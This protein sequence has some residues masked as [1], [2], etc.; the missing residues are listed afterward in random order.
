MENP[1]NINIFSNIQ[2][3]SLSKPE[4]ML[5][6]LT[7]NRSRQSQQFDIN[8]IRKININK[9]KASQKLKLTYY[10]HR[11][12]SD[13]NHPKHLL[14]RNKNNQ[15]I[16]F[17]VNNSDFNDNMNECDWIIF[18]FDKKYIP[19]KF[20]IKNNGFKSDVEIMRVCIGDIKKNKWRESQNINVKCRSKK[21]IFDISGIAKKSKYHHLKLLFL[22]NYGEM[23]PDKPRFGINEFGLY[24]IE[25]KYALF[26]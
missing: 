26:Q 14:L 13:N 19:S 11:G 17:S 22:R 20:Y 1:L 18:K 12:H 24:G 8:D 2:R 5:S 21:Q 3:C 4:D 7:S 16:Y 23:N 6:V 10:S 25:K 9:H 15:F